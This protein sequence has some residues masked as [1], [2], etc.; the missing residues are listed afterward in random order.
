MPEIVFRLFFCIFGLL[1]I[2]LALDARRMSKL[3]LTWPSVE[4]EIR[5]ACIETDHV[6]NSASPRITYAYVV[7]EL[8]YEA[9]Q[10]S[11]G[12]QPASLYRSRQVVASYPVGSK[13]LV[14]YNPANP[15]SAVIERGKTSGLWLFAAFGAGCVA[16]SA[17]VG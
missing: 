3:A 9:N 15:Q 4:G 8:T 11:Y 10:F 14:Y 13:V 7:N 17:L 5:K 6:S 1:F 12:C 16:F 2:W